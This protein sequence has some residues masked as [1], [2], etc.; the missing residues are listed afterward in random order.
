MAFVA[1]GVV[2]ALMMAAEHP[3][4]RFR[5]RQNPWTAPRDFQQCKSNLMQ[6]GTALEMYSTD[7]SGRYPR[8]LAPLLPNYLKVLPT[9]PSRGQPTY[10][11]DSASNPDA[12]TLVCGG[13]NH[14]YQGAPA[15]YPQYN[16]IVGGAMEH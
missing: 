14:P 16:S 12:Y 3:D 11:Y 9:C 7:A 6:V 4:L 13:V 8:S 2:V 15:N 5:L 1:P 10:V